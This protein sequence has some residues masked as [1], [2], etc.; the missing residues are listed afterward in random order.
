[1]CPHIVQVALATDC[2]GAPR[3]DESADCIAI[4]A[5]D[6]GLSKWEHWT[7]NSRWIG[8]NQLMY[9]LEGAREEGNGSWKLIRAEPAVT[10]SFRINTT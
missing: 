10:W 4:A 5:D 8:A 3:G 2:V 9:Q 6:W 7:V 1:M